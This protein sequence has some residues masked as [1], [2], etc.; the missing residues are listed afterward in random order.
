MRPRSI[1]ACK[2]CV[3]VM[4]QMEWK[5]ND[6]VFLNK[7]KK[8]LKWLSVVGEGGTLT[9]LL[10]DDGPCGRKGLFLL[11]L[12]LELLSNNNTTFSFSSFVIAFEQ[13]H[14]F[15]LLLEPYML[16]LLLAGRPRTEFGG[17]GN[18]GRR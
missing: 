1:S 7:R 5:I 4:F 6:F 13:Q 11:L 3:K 17:R 16:V 9:V 10:V 12:L 18:Y 14:Y 8:K 2:M 15:L